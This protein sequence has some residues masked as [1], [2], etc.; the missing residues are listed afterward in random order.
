MVCVRDDAEYELAKKVSEKDFATI[1]IERIVAF[2]AWYYRISPNIT[3]QVILKIKK[4]ENRDYI[5]SFI[6]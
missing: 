5:V 3:G 6:A 4:S 2:E 1:N